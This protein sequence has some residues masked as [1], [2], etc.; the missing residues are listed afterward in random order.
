MNIVR[1]LTIFMILAALSF[2]LGFF[3]LA[4][5]FPAAPKQGGAGSIAPTIVTDSMAEKT[6]PT[7]STPSPPAQLASGPASIASNIPVQ[8]PA[9]QP[10]KASRTPGPSLDPVNDAAGIHSG[11]VVQKPHRLETVAAKSPDPASEDG[12]ATTSGA[13]KP[14]AVKAAPPE[15]APPVTRPKK[16][17][18]TTPR[19]SQADTSDADGS[20]DYASE[21]T[22][23]RIT[24]PHKAKARHADSSDD[25][26]DQSETTTAKPKLKV[27]DTETASSGLFHVHLGAFHSRDA[28]T[29]EVERARAKGFSTQIVQVTRNGRTLY[30]VQAGAFRDRV[31]AETAQQSLQEANLD[32]RISDQKR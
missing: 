13:E 19:I 21:A 9:E 2:V 18:K 14:A 29:S 26:G 28:A 12:S 25:S 7:N 1:T 8:K 17:H 32:A 16:K 3:V 15:D 20:G 24:I 5:L 31:N 6:A 10:T 23:R 4:R 27:R 11:P 30:R 22:T